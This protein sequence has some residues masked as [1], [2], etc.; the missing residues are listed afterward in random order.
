[1]NA[2]EGVAM[3]LLILA[4]T[5]AALILAVSGCGGGGA[6]SA[7]PAPSVP[8]E[9]V[10]PATSGDGTE[11]P[12]D[13]LQNSGDQLVEYFAQADA[14]CRAAT[15]KLAAALPELPDETGS[16]AA[17]DLAFPKSDLAFRISRDALAE[18]RALP[19][20]NV[21][22]VTPVALCSH[23]GRTQESA[24]SPTRAEYIAQANEICRAATSRFNSEYFY[25][26]LREPEGAQAA[27]QIEEEALAQLRAL[28]Q[29]E[30]DRALLEEG[31]Y[32]VV[33]QEIDALRAS[34][35]AA[36]DGDPARELLV[37]MERV[38]LTHQRD[39]FVSEYG[40]EIGPGAGCPMELPA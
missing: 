17:G 2:P 22:A 11:G 12:A 26:G 30:A 35:A 32:Q 21:S 5:A 8:V 27:A 9:T 38:H 4:L 19:P 3:K 28:P 37:G 33:E 13:Y 29:P 15:D 25:S 6:E 16:E 40:L 23:R 34:A 1:M 24:N 10:S 18:L 31:F 36:A 20:P 39:G 14:I 7:G